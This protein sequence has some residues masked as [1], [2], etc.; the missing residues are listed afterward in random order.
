MIYSTLKDIYHG[1]M[2]T[3]PSCLLNKAVDVRFLIISSC[4]SMHNRKINALNISWC[5]SIDC[6]LPPFLSIRKIISS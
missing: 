6:S 5:Y 4:F 3:F 1:I 2:N